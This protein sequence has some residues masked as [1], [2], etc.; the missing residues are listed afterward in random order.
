MKPTQA[1]ID[2]EK[3]LRTK[4]LLQK[5]KDVADELRTAPTGMNYAE[6]I[7]ALVSSI[8]ELKKRI[9]TLEV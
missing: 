8:Q 2:K 4:N 6:I 3:N 7:P 5:R 1:E 9:E